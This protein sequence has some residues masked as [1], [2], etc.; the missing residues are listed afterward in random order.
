M[1]GATFFTSDDSVDWIESS[2]VVFFG[3]EQRVSRLA[4]LV[5][6]VLASSGCEEG[7]ATSP[8]QAGSGSGSGSGSAVA[9]APAKNPG[10]GFSADLAKKLDTAG[11]ASDTPE[12]TNAGITAAGSADAKAGSAEAKVADA[13]A[14][15]ADVKAGSA[16]MKAGSANTMA[17]AKAGSA[18][19]PADTKPADTKVADT[20]V[21]D[22]KVADAKVADAKV[23][24]PKAGSAATKVEPPKSGS[25]T[26]TAPK[27]DGNVV[28][29]T[30]PS[31][32]P[33]NTPAEL[34]AINISLL[35]NWERDVTSAGTIS[36]AVKVPGKTDIA[37]FVF[38]Y[39]I[40]DA[41]APA[42]RDAYKKWLA[43]N[44][45]FVSK[46]DR[47]KGAAWYLEGVDGTGKPAFRMVVIYGGKKLICYGSL[48]KDSALGDLRDQTIIQA[49]QICETLTL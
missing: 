40:E 1:P 16:D 21:A 14:G 19:K 11:S 4:G 22:T 12:R 5:I 28:I 34:K 38:H 26:G 6:F 49:K 2:L 27:I 23:A 47:Q 43:D 15:S 8:G 25:A 31:K 36:L 10:G 29:A 24:D 30:T 48:Y 35:P 39:G 45:L 46:D 37:T 41:K 42:D 20:K 33:V 13:K 9:T 32:G 7:G 18:A 44:K 3:Y 17:D